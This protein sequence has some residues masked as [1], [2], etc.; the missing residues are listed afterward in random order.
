M[1]CSAITPPSLCSKLRPPAFRGLSPESP[2]TGAGGE[3]LT[4]RPC[5]DEG[6]RGGHCDRGGPRLRQVVLA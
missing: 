3:G 6:V 1:L 4:H 2:S 5:R